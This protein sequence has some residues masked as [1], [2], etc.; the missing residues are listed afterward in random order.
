MYVQS[1][2]GGEVVVR[3]LP[4]ATQSIVCEWH[5]LGLSKIH[6]ESHTRHHPRRSGLAISLVDFCAR[7]KAR[8][9]VNSALKILDLLA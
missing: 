9:L 8:E 7:P 5:P 3:T 1:F 2:G 6:S 4:V